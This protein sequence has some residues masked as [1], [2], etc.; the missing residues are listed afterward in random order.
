MKRLPVLAVAIAALTIGAL[1]VPLAGQSRTA[2][3]PAAKP[4]AKSAAPPSSPA[5]AAARA[6]RPVPFRMG[7]VLTYDVS[8]SSYVTAGTATVTV[9]EKRP[10]YGSTAYYIVAEGRPTPLLSKLY[11]LYYKA[12]TLLDSYSLLPQR[13]VVYSE[14]GRDRRTKTTSFNQGAKTAVYEVQ[15]ATNVRKDLRLPAFAQDALS[16]IYVLRAI[17]MKQGASITMPVTDSG[18]VYKVQVVV[19][20]REPVRAGG[21]TTNAWKVIPTLI[22]AKG[23]PS[24]RAMAMW[25]SDD[26]R[27]VPLKLQA[28]LAVGSFVLT[29]REAR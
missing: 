1:D 25:I 26:E 13:G 28:D 14:E 2:R 16:A 20:S 23:K 9:R 5:P 3:K 21:A 4:A 27:K 17:P 15:T 11:T 22:D 24:A 18:T 6:E 19:G 7:E 29:L 8:W 12:E 10:S